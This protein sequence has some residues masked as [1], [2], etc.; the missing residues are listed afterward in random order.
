MRNVEHAECRGFHT[1][2][3]FK[4]FLLK[5]TLISQNIEISISEADRKN[6]S[7]KMGDMIARNPKNHEDQWLVAKAYFEDNLEL[8]KMESSNETVGTAKPLVSFGT[9]IKALKQGKRACR[10]GWNGKGLFIFEQMPSSVPAEIVPVM[11]SLPQSVKNEFKK[12]FE[13][14][15][16]S[17]NNW[18]INYHNQIAL[19]KP[20]N[21]INGWSPSTADALAEDW[22]VL[23]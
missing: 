7:P 5:N 2:P 3:I 19:V 15:P 8:I 10:K 13:A 18:G 21:D 23:D 16:D 4:G 22:I 12:R 17:S 11:T 20:N 1:S 6:G 14:D 9:A